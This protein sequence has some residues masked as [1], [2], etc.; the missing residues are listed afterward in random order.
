MSSH[1]TGRAPGRAAMPKGDVVR[2]PDGKRRSRATAGAKRR[3]LAALGATGS[4][5]AGAV[6]ADRSKGAVY[7]WR[8]ADPVF[9]QQWEDSLTVALASLETEAYRRAV[10]GREVPVVSG[11]K[12]VTTV[13]RYSDHLLGL[14]LRMHAPERYAAR[15]AEIARG[16]QGPAKKPVQFTFRIGN[17][18]PGVAGEGDAGPEMDGTLEA[19]MRGDGPGG[20]DRSPDAV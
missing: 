14:L 7:A 6:A 9:A 11:G 4:V 8:D 3:F 18:P 2:G 19:A 5:V 13:R 15:R 17:V 12:I 1:R 20:G 10:E 16:V